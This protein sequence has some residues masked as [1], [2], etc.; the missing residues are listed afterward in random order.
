MARFVNIFSLAAMLG[1]AASAAQAAPIG[2]PAGPIF[3]QFN[4][5]E[6]LDTS[7]GNAISVPG[8]PVDVNGDGAA[9]TPGNGPLGEGNWGVFNVS[10]IQFGAVVIPNQEISGGTPFFADDGPGGTAGQVSG[11]FYNHKPHGSDDVDRWL[12]G[13]LL[14]RCRRPG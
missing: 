2:L 7:G 8:A 14:G 11:I 4:N 1:V 3:F 12:P 5:I 13:H 10:T 6:Q 9:D